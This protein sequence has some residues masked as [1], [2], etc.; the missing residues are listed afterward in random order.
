M[1]NTELKIL[2]DKCLLFNQFMIEKGGIPSVLAEAYKESNRLIE[3]AYADGNP[4][5]LKAMNKDIDNQVLKHMPLQMAADFKKIFKEK[6]GI[7][8]EAV[9]KVYDKAIEKILKK[10]KIVNAEE[11]ELILTK[12]DEIYA[13]PNKEVEV[14]RLNDLLTAYHQEEH[15]N[16]K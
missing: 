14:K 6:L 1:K 7:D 8:F 16:K 5:P 4:K 12:V 3:K 2:R 9:D 13:D 10:G 15:Q 11:Y